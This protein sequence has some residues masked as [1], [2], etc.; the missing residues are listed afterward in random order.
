[1]KKYRA[2]K[3]DL[4][5]FEYGVRSDDH[6][7]IGGSDEDEDDDL[8]LDGIPLTKTKT[9]H[10]DLT[11]SD[12][13][14]EHES[15]QEVAVPKVDEMKFQGP[16][17]VAPAHLSLVSPIITTPQGMLQSWRVRTTELG[18]S[19]EWVQSTSLRLAV[20][21]LN[22]NSNL[23]ITAD[24]AILPTLEAQTQAPS[25]AP[26]TKRRKLNE[27]EDD[28]QWGGVDDS[29]F[30]YVPYHP[31]RQ[32]NQEPSEPAPTGDDISARGPV[33]AQIED[34]VHER[35]HNDRLEQEDDVDYRHE[36]NHA[37]ARR[38]S[39]LDDREESQRNADHHDGGHESSMERE[40]DHEYSM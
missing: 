36:I 5:Q 23:T 31:I 17:D 28:D 26:P 40:F 14:H 34:L 15:Q 20:A 39:H 18:S 2:L 35:E 4:Q 8:N 27:Q 32:L 21:A 6:I 9:A 1:M 13:E 10:V 30:Q 25:A 11:R 38:E 19:A 16:D 22:V 7:V 29:V 3:D 12:D 33:H 24:A 37:Y